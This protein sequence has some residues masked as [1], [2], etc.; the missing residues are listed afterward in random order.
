MSKEFVK[1]FKDST[2]LNTNFSEY[3]V[4]LIEKLAQSDKKII[5]VALSG[6]SLIEA[7]SRSVKPLKSRIEPFV[8]KLVFLFADERFVRLDHEDSTYFGYLKQDFFSTLN[9]PGSNIYAI[10]S[11]AENVEECAKDYENRLKPLLNSNN[12]FDILLLGAG[13]D[14]HICSLFPSHPLF[15]NANEIN[16]LV[17]PITDSPKPPPQRVTLTL[18]YLQNSSY[19]LFWLCGENKAEMIRKS[20]L[21]NDASLPITIAKPNNSDATLLWFCDSLAAKYL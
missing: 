15:V 14:G 11:N 7:F 4:Q 10:K 2:E 12:G 13:P 16:D 3:F 18:K 6:G 21:D 17:V 1:I 9:I 5:T 19:L 8:H 20:I